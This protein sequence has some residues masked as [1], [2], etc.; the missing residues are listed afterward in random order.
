VKTI[1]PSELSA[2]PHWFVHYP[3]LCIIQKIILV[4]TK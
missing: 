3:D 4:C 1:R 2:Q